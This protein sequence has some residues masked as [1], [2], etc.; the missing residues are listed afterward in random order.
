[1]TSQLKDKPS[2]KDRTPQWSASELRRVARI[3]ELGIVI[4]QRLKKGK[5]NEQKNN[6]PSED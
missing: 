4:D 6:E 2:Q 3:L 1:M 5:S